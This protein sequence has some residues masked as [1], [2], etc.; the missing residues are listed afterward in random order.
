MDLYTIVAPSADYIA[1]DELYL[2]HSSPELHLIAR[3]SANQYIT[4]PT[5]SYPGI[6]GVPVIELHPGSNDIILQ[7]YRDYPGGELTDGEGEPK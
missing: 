3:L 7:Y 5:D 2:T 1:A 6:D 4:E